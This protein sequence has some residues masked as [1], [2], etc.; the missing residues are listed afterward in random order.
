[1]IGIDLTRRG[2]DATAA[3]KV[4]KIAKSAAKPSEP[5]S[6]KHKV[7]AS[8]PS[9]DEAPSI[10]SAKEGEMGVKRAETRKHT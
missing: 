9:S 10:P 1:V 3:R 5:G 4:K 8:L 7:A 6:R 2:I